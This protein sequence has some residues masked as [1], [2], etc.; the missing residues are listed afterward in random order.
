MKKKQPEQLP[1]P[2]VS[3]WKENE[4]VTRLRHASIPVPFWKTPVPDNAYL[5]DYAASVKEKLDAGSGLIIHSQDP[6]IGTAAACAVARCAL[7]I[8]SRVM[9]TEAP[10]LVKAFIEKL[11]WSEDDGISMDTAIRN[12]RLLVIDN[13]GREYRGSGSGYSEVHLGNLVRT[14]SNWRRSTILVTRMSFDALTQ[15]YSDYLTQ[16]V[17]QTLEWVDLEE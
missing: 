6:T 13:L 8:S 2:P 11:M 1:P 14:R 12:R 15:V 9:Y 7:E 3:R 4:W 5:Q 17:G 16:M 10:F